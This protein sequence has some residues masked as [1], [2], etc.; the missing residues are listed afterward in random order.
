M[1]RFRLFIIYMSFSVHLLVGLC[2]SLIQSSPPPPKHAI[3]RYVEFVETPKPREDK[4]NSFARQADVPPELLTERPNAKR[5]FS[6]EKEQT[7]LEETRAPESGLTKNRSDIAKTPTKPR[8][9]PEAFTP[10]PTQSEQLRPAPLADTRDFDDGIESG[11]REYT[12]NESAPARGKPLQFPSMARF[13][14]EQGRSSFGEVAPRDLKIGQ[15]T[16]LNTDRFLYYSF[17]ERA[18]D[19]VYHHWA[20]YVR[21]VL[22]SYQ[23]SGRATGDEYWITRI[24]I[25]LDKDG[26]F[27][28]GLL[29]Q[30][31]GLQ[32]LDL[33]PVHAFRDA[34]QIPHPPP[35]MISEDGTIRMDWEFA[36]QMIPTYAAGK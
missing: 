29:H 1:E 7:V 22:Y 21:A 8:S 35:E 3:D 15:M 14:L 30:G 25:V 2:L 6:S 5:R 4:R 10:Q 12:E 28:K 24:E 17:Y 11:R 23:R 13:G 33:A 18:Q 19:L 16:A 32:S 9:I 34:K 26:R 31:S 20:K 27:L 36:V